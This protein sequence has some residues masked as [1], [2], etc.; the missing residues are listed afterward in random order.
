MEE[1]NDIQQPVTD[2]MI[3][4]LRETARPQ[5]DIPQEVIERYMIRD[6]Q[7]IYNTYW[8]YRE[9]AAM[10]AN[11][12]DARARQLV[13]KS[14]TGNY[15][16]A[17]MELKLKEKT[18]K[19][20]EMYGWLQQKEALIDS[21]R[22]HC[23]QQRDTL[24]VHMKNLAAQRQQILSLLSHIGDEDGREALADCDASWRADRWK[25]AM[26]YINAVQQ[27]LAEL[28][29]AVLGQPLDEGVKEALLSVVG[30]IRNNARRAYNRTAHIASPVLRKEFAVET[31]PED[32]E[33][34]QQ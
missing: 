24:A 25:E 9:L 34:E 6:Y 7:R 8:E 33:K 30:I 11:Q 3:E 14:K 15:V 27:Q 31:V 5:D 17:D 19:I 32:E 13:K 28:R 26:V 29:E 12:I 4:A 20:N 21:L 18:R 23:E 2:D 22:F 10:T 1:N 16:V